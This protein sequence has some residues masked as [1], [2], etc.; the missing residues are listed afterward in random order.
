MVPA[1][2]ISTSTVLKAGYLHLCDRE[3]IS[4]NHSTQDI[5]PDLVKYYDERDFKNVNINSC[6]YE[7]STIMLYDK[8]KLI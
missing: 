4:S 6:P 1:A 5:V 2:A 3:V 8:T 7:E